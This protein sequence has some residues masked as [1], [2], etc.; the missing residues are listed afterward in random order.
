M[1]PSIPNRVQP[2][3]W[4]N[5]RKNISVGHNTDIIQTRRQKLSQNAR[6]MIEKSLPSIDYQL[7]ITCQLVQITRPVRACLTLRTSLLGIRTFCRTKKFSLSDKNFRQQL[8]ILLYTL[9]ISSLAMLNSSATLFVEPT[10]V[11]PVFWTT[12][13]FT[14]S[15]LLSLNYLACRPQNNWLFIIQPKET[16]TWL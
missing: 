11:S 16:Q 5:G 4:P 7:S 8:S 3:K 2:A 1:T 15:S 14:K 12:L 9:S 13:V 10:L 6:F